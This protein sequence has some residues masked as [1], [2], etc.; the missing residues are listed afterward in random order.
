MRAVRTCVVPGHESCEV[1][2]VGK[3]PHIS[4]QHL[5]TIA[6]GNLHMHTTQRCESSKAFL[7][8][9]KP[10]VF[11][12]AVITRTLLRQHTMGQSSYHGSSQMQL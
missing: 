6:S 7:K 2:V 10:T 9:T 5:L 3:P 4:A 11:R 12:N 8:D 1:H